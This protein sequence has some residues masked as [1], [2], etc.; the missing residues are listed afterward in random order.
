MLVPV[1]GSTLVQ[2]ASTISM[3][4]SVPGEWVGFVSLSEGGVG[5]MRV[6][7]DGPEIKMRMLVYNNKRTL[8]KDLNSNK[9]SY[10]LW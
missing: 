7:S 2:M 4:R 10:N 5:N 3:P 8:R 6:N 9:K 1:N